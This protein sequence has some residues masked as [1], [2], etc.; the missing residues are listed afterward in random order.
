MKKTIL[1]ITAIFVASFAANAQFVETSTS[2]TYTGHSIPSGTPGFY[3]YQAY[4]STQ[5]SDATCS[6][7]FSGTLGGFDPSFQDATAIGSPRSNGGAIIFGGGI[8]NVYS[9]SPCGANIPSFGFNSNGVDLSAA[10]NQKITF[11]YQSDAT[12]NL[13]LQVKDVF[14][15]GMLISTPFT[16]VGDGNVHT[17]SLDF[18]GN[19]NGAADLSSI[20]QISFG[21]PTSTLS[22]SFGVSLNNIKL[23]S[24][25]VTAIN[26]STSVANANLFPNPS[27]GTTTISGELKS[28]ANVKI[29]L[30]DMLGQEV[31]VIS[32]EYTSTINST[33]DVSTLK[34]GI[35]SVVT[36]IDGAPSKSQML[37]VR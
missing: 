3:A 21:F 20:R 4:P 17:I 28:V 16:L 26:N 37:V 6:T 14:Y 35:Y 33:F 24:A 5:F 13:E 31:K 36:N 23:G 9:G 30:V 18:S 1:S 7:A 27:T 32:E 10:A 25:V 19:I 29:T 22:P 2:V 15:N 34:K 11:E 12:L 8:A